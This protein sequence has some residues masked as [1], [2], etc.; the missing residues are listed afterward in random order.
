MRVH[1]SGRAF[2]YQTLRAV[3][4]TTFGGAE[5]GE[6]LTTVDRI[7]EGDTEAW[8]AEWRRT[9]ER[10]ERSAAAA[11]AAGNDRT[12]RAAYFRAHNYHR[13]AEFFLPAAD[14]RR[15][16]AYEKSRAAFRAGAERLDAPVRRLD[17]PYEDTT[18]PGYLF[19]PSDET[20]VIEPYRTIV[21]V[22][23]F[24]SVAEEL[25]F[26]C[27]VPE[28][29]ARGYAVVLFDGPGQG[30]PLREQGLTAR[31]DWE[32]VV[33][34]VLDALG[35]HD[36]VESQGVGLVGASFGGYY[37]PRAAA[38]EDRIAAC[39]AFDHM[40]DLWR[41]ASYENP[42]LASVVARAPDAIVNGFA[43]FAARVSVESR[44][45]MEN[46]KWVFG[47]T[48]AAEFQRTLPR[49][50]LSGVAGEIDCPTLV[51][52]GEDDHFVPLALA[53]EFVDELAGPTTLRVFRTEEGAG[54]HCQVGNLRLATGVIYD[55]FDETLARAPRS[56]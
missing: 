55:W 4:Y 41:A 9:A 40:H 19:L 45:L 26:L 48:S 30:A 27:G 56:A 15:R 28:A 18:L 11:A 22:G 5:P 12:A 31:P 25:F 42:R 3:A 43:T 7:D 29:L 46:S 35:E 21:C 2:D 44:W 36:A 37:A 33:G 53:Q 34:P 13:S 38:F 54:E 49:Y 20:P 10:V 32:R 1:F 23:G 39:V 24:D 8:H 16:P 50:S 6:V 17:V 52:A 14:P 51:L 47:V